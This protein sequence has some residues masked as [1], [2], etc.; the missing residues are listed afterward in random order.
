MSFAGLILSQDLLA[1]LQSD[2]MKRVL[3]ECAQV[4]GAMDRFDL[5]FVPPL[6]LD[7][8]VFYLSPPSHQP[9]RASAP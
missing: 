1:L 3:N 7:G 5:L 9:T 8:N 2:D 6:L 4:P